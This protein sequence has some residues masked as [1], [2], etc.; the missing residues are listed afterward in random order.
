MINY[1]KNLFTKIKPGQQWIDKDYINCNYDL[2]PNVIQIVDVDGDY[3]L[4]KY[5]LLTGDSQ[6]ALKKRIKEFYSLSERIHV[7]G[8]SSPLGQ[9]IKKGTQISIG[10]MK[11]SFKVVDCE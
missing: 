9:S 11:G 2:G 5:P 8:L 4:I 7:K 3:C 1:F 6:P 10:G